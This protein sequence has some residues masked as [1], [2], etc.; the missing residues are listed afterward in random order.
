MT[1]RLSQE[2]LFQAYNEQHKQPLTQE[3]L[4]E[5]EMEELMIELSEGESIYSFSHDYSDGFTVMISGDNSLSDFGLVGGENYSSKDT[6][7]DMEALGRVLEHYFNHPLDE[8]R[9]LFGPGGPQTDE[10]RELRSEIEERLLQMH[11]NG[12]NMSIVGKALGMYFKPNRVCP[13]MARAL[14]RARKNR[15]EA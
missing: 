6:S 14:K 15:E 4:E 2:E 5:A 9:A 10:T 11:E 3:E 12:G 1:N 13:S 8:V 7:P